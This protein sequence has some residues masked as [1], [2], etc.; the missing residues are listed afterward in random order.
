MASMRHMHDT[1]TA[2]QASELQGRL[3]HDAHVISLTEA[4]KLV[5]HRPGDSLQ[6]TLVISARTPSHCAAAVRSN[7]TNDIIIT[8]SMSTTSSSGNTAVL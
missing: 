8:A 7:P 1:C 2:G 4:H 3:L 6:T 5:D